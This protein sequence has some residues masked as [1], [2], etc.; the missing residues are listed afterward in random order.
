MGAIDG[1]SEV[2]ITSLN[3]NITVNG[4]VLLSPITPYSIHCTY[5]F[6]GINERQIDGQCKVRL[7]ALNGFIIINGNIE[8]I[9]SLYHPFYSY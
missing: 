9:A 2:H 1:W 8:V 5:I 7:E 4:K 6:I 3:G